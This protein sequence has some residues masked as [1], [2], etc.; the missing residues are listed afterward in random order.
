MSLETV[1]E[2]RIYIG[3]FRQPVTENDLRSRFTP[4][5][6]VDSVELPTTADTK[7]SRGFGYVSIK[8]TP[9]QWQR[10]TSIYGGTKWK[11][12]MLRIEEAKETYLVRL[13]RERKEMIEAAGHPSQPAKQQKRSYSEDVYLGTMADDMEL[14]TAK[15]VDRYRGWSKGRYNRPVLKYKMIKANGKSFTFDPV[16]YRNNFE[17]LFGSVRP[18][19]WQDL[20][21]EYD[22]IQ[23]AEDFELARR[24]PEGV[25]ERN[26]AVSK[27]MAKRMRLEEEARREQE[28]LKKEKELELE[29]EPGRQMQAGPVEA[30]EF[31]IETVKPEVPAVDAHRWAADD[32]DL[33]GM[34]ADEKVVLD[35]NAFEGAEELAALVTDA[36]A[37][38]NPDLLA[39]LASG[40]FDSD[41]DSDSGSED[42]ERESASREND[43]GDDQHNADSASASASAAIESEESTA[44]SLNAQAA[45]SEEAALAK[46]R[47]RMASIL[48][49]ILGGEI[50]SPTDVSKPVV[51]LDF[52]NEVNSSSALQDGSDKKS[53]NRKGSND[54]EA[55]DSS[56][57]GSSDSESSSGSD[58]GDDDSESSSG[59]GSSSSSSDEEK[60]DDDEKD[61]SE[62]DS[63]SDSDSDSDLD[64]EK[65]EDAQS[66]MMEIDTQAES[67]TTSGNALFG[68]SAVGFRFTDAL[69]LEADEP[70]A[71]G[72]IAEQEHEAPVTGGA[73]MAGEPIER[74]LN[75]NRLPLFFADVD[76]ITFKRP[77]PTFQRQKTEEE[78]QADLD[79]ARPKLAREFRSQHQAV[80]RQTRKM[81]EK[82]RLKK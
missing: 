70:S 21:W 26:E 19:H 25:V 30:A 78:L 4:F 18:K 12:G 68:G 20:L 64:S 24:L 57:S 13:E 2:K 5:G 40:V 44:R 22:A 61:T 79:K 43:S 73:R 49:K 37:K 52:E 59:S 3:G 50:N 62:S 67:E 27:R 14:V 8:I 42:D 6:Q 34:D 46:E 45:S 16:Q 33:E 31:D 17:K 77:E 48:G 54:K 76:A 15:N 35:L 56:D 63:E 39:K 82:R 60:D 9:S 71:L 23:A 47:E 10:C 1:L 58:S 74:N 38:S 29:L 81:Q 7:E 75:A 11:G 80:A 66:D 32:S 65:Y 72:Q 55:S 51:S 69:G 36:S 28:R 41:S 53:E